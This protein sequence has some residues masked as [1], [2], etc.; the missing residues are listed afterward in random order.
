MLDACFIHD[1]YVHASGRML[2]I[3]VSSAAIST[4]QYASHPQISS[5]VACQR[6]T[7]RSLLLLSQL[8]HW[9]LWIATLLIGGRPLHPAARRYSRS[10][11]STRSRALPTYVGLCLVPR[12]AARTPLFCISGVEPFLYIGDWRSNADRCCSQWPRPE[13]R[14]MEVCPWKRSRGAR[15]QDGDLV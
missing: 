4:K 5:L 10:R 3:H 7:F 6:G 2:V 1:R 9:N 15:L 12:L 8:P 11:S 13:D 14:T